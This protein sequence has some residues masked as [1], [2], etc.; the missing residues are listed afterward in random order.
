MFE[1]WPPNLSPERAGTARLREFL[2][3]QRTWGWLVP[4]NFLIPKN[5]G[6]SRPRPWGR[7]QTGSKLSPR[8]VSKPEWTRTSR[9]AGRA[10]ALEER[11][12]NVA[13][14]LPTG[15]AVVIGY[16]PE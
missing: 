15:R 2:N 14:I 13:R 9:F 10:S 8:D 3:T 5:V 11:G 4:A 7:M 1:N 16:Q 6:T 12:A